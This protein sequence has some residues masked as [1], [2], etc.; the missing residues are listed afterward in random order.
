MRVNPYLTADLLAAL[1]RTQQE[2]QTALLQLSS[3]KRINQPSDDPAGTA[4]LL[5][6]QD[7]LD[8]S[9]QYLQSIGSVRGQLQTADS[10]L[11]SVG[12]ALQRAVSLGIE[13]ANG[14]LSDANRAS[15]ATELQGI[16]DQVVS[17]AN[18]SFQGRYLFSGTATLTKPYTPDPNAALGIRY[19]GNAG[20]N[21]VEIGDGF[22]LQTN[23][24]GSQVFGTGGNSMFQAMQ[25]LIQAMQSG[26]GI[27]AAVSGVRASY[28]S[29]SQH[30]VFYGNAV[31]QLD[32]QTTSLKSEKVEL[33]SQQEAVAGADPIAAASQLSNAQNSRQATLQGMAKVMQVNLF[34]YLR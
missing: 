6:L 30:R 9:D 20:T 1:Q 17:L 18:T 22:R 32:A 29:I 33:S 12:L 19:D 24:P 21:Q 5:R 26:T 4:I 2:E 3:G 14:T 7:R 34:D 27:D 28:D 25:N 11:N 23:Q 13:G 10:A 31:N 16:Q 15:I 8:S